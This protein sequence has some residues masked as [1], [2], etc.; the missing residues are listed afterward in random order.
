MAVL[1]E[2]DSLDSRGTD[3]YQER[4]RDYLTSKNMSAN[5]TCVYCYAVRQFFEIHKELTI[6]TLQ[7]YKVYLLEHYKPQTV[8][9]R[10][11]ALNC[12]MEYLN[13]K[14]SK[15]TMI[16]IQQK[17]YLDRIISQADYEYLKRRLWEDG[18][19]SYYFVIRY[20]AATGVR[21]SELV[22]FEI[23]DVKFGFKDIY[24]KGNKMRRIYIPTV[25]KQ[26]TE[27]WLEKSKRNKGALFLNRFGNPI[28][29][30]GIRGQLKTFALRYNLDPE[31]V[32]PHSFR[33]RFAKNFIENSGD[34]ALL[35]DLLGHESIETTRIYLRRSSSE[36]YRIVNKIVDW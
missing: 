11:R 25:L 5:T 34:I 33:H 12:Y 28:T 6:A 3:L 27:V 16:K 19:F 13:H 22:K 2:A 9:L 18:E 35:S 29:A 14:D 15:M 1:K 31:V 7:L 26:K 24:S 17:M 21:I 8:N 30:S 32:Y 20:M 23:A 10:I 4:F 36:Q